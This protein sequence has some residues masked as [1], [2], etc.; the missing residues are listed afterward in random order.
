MGRTFRGV[1]VAVILIVV[2]ELQADARAVPVLEA[3][4]TAQQLAKGEST[5]ADAAHG[6]GKVAQL[7]DGLVVA[8]NLS[9]NFRGRRKVQHAGVVDVNPR[10]RR[11]A[12][13]YDAALGAEEVG[14]VVQ[15]GRS[16]GRR[17]RL[18][19]PPRRTALRPLG[20]PADR[21]CGGLHGHI[22]QVRPHRRRNTAVDG[23]VLKLRRV[24]NHVRRRRRRAD[25]LAIGGSRHGAAGAWMAMPP[26]DAFVPGAHGR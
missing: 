18:R 7:E 26:D 24:R 19:C 2:V 15:L 20:V 25:A 23:V 5:A 9:V 4:H 12:D 16:G 3:A 17:S 8:G 13:R 1:V 10:D 21:P 22:A 14:G 11:L 6:E